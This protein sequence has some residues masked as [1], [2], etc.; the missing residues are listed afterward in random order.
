MSMERLTMPKGICQMASTEYCLSHRDCY[1]CGHG[2]KVFQTLAAYED[3]GLEPEDIN[4]MLRCAA[5]DG[6]TADYDRLRELAE[7]DKDGRRVV[8][9]CK[10]GDTVYEASYDCAKGI[11]YNPFNKNGYS[12]AEI[13][14]KCDIN[15]CDLHRTVREKITQSIDWIW[16]NKK[17]FSKTVFLTRAEA[18]AALKGEADGRD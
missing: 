15:P 17:H 10:V 3:T 9:P 13:C 18:E 1:E 6:E 12:Y 11:R 5:E 2:R 4:L 14:L 8:L 16:E 7:A